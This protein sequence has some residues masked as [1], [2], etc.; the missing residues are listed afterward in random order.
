MISGLT[1]DV[2]R[3]LCCIFPS[4]E[5][6]SAAVH[7]QCAVCRTACMAAAVCWWL[8]AWLLLQLLMELGQ[9]GEK[10]PFPWYQERE[11]LSGRPHATTSFRCRSEIVHTGVP[12]TLAFKPDLVF[13]FFH[14]IPFV[15]CV[16][17]VKKGFIELDGRPCTGD[18]DIGKRNL[19][20][21]SSWRD[22]CTNIN[23]A[24]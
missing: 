18:T 16:C 2:L 4:W 10:A 6:D 19:N 17:P 23:T 9:L 1:S 7:T 24:L 3:P 5:T 13:P 20:P 14:F 15:V 11:H 8:S 12:W 22:P 21:Q